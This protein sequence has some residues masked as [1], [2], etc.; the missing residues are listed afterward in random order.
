MFGGQLANET[1]T[2]R[3]CSRQTQFGAQGGSSS[4]EAILFPPVAVHSNSSETTRHWPRLPG[5]AA[6]PLRAP[7]SGCQRQSSSIAG[8]RLGV[9]LAPNIAVQ[10]MVDAPPKQTFRR[11]ARSTAV[12]GERTM[13]CGRPAFQSLQN[14]YLLQGDRQLEW[15]PHS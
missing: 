8:L 2:S 9:C 5:L 6:S 11:R 3:Q 13:R 12:G 7:R 4:A 15:K 1:I 14:L 10:P